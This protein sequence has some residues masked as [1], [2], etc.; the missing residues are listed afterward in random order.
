M[1]IKFN[2]FNNGKESNKNEY[3]EFFRSFHF[4][5]NQELNHI[6]NPQLI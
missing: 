1:S 6:F 5:E 4:G 2:P 3:Q